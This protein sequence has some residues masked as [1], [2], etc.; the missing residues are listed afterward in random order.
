MPITS[1]AIRQGREPERCVLWLFGNAT[2]AG[3][4]S[5]LASPQHHPSTPLACST[6]VHASTHRLRKVAPRTSCWG[7]A[8]V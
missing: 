5:S 7:Y 6:S 4:G 1:A 2:G 3:S 8:M